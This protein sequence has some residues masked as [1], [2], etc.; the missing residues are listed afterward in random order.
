MSAKKQ[1]ILLALGLVVVVLIGG[2]MVYL[3]QQTKTAPTISKKPKVYKGAEPNTGVDLSKLTDGTYYVYHK[4]KAYPICSDVQTNGIEA[5]SNQTDATRLI[6]MDS[7][8]T[9]KIPTLYLGSNDKLIYR[10]TKNAINTIRYE[11]YQDDGYSFGIYN[12]TEQPN[13][14]FTVNLTG[15]DTSTSSTKTNVRANSSA[16]SISTA[17]TDTKATYT[18]ASIGSGKKAVPL[19]K[20]ML[21]IGGFVKS[22]VLVSNPKAGTTV[23][24]ERVYAVNVYAGT[25]SH[26]FDIKSDTHY[27]SGMELYAEYTKG[28]DTSSTY[29]EL[30]IPDYLPDGY[31]VPNFGGMFRL[32]HGKEYTDTAENFNKRQLEVQTTHDIQ[33]DTTVASKTGQ[34]SCYSTSTELNS[35]STTNPNAFGYNRAEE[36]TERDEGD[37]SVQAENT[38]KS[39]AIKPKKGKKYTITITATRDDGSVTYETPVDGWKFDMK[40]NNDGT[41]TFTSTIT[42]NGKD[43]KILVKGF[44]KDVTADLNGADAEV[45]KEETT[46]ADTESDTENTESDTEDTEAPDI[47]L[48]MGGDS[49]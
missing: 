13:H 11:R 16:Q 7:A 48:S 3:K 23:P 1:K 32:V 9:K 25:E 12:V 8:T 45:T 26:T 27:F 20:K 33:T 24:E 29:Q 36:Q 18:L 10:N 4:G 17:L 22:D 21:S 15:S 46:N 19:T 43:N 14:T 47:D 38:E 39:F 49:E 34:T 40:P 28:L 42:G 31:Y 41:V 37:T 30:E 35:Y 5:A 44:K 2:S 6:M